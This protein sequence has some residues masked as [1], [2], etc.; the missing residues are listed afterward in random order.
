MPDEIMQ[1][2]WAAKDAIAE[3]AGYDLDKLCRLLEEWQV[4]NRPESP[5]T[6]A[7][8]NTPET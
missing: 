6:Q 5:E 1:E 8:Q 2:L 3:E 4:E 7:A